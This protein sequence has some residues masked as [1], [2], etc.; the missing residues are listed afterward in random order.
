MI[1]LIHV[2][3]G[4]LRADERTRRVVPQVAEFGDGRLEERDRALGV[5]TIE[6]DLSQAGD[7]AGRRGPIARGTVRRQR[8]IEVRLGLRVVGNG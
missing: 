1:E 8:L 4:Q 5:A 6:L 3:A 7:R 2:G